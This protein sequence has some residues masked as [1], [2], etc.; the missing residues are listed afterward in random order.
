MTV[1]RMVQAVLL[2]AALRSPAASS[3]RS[4]GVTSE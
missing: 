1:K 4:S 3:W 2:I